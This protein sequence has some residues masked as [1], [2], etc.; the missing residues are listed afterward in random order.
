MELGEI[1]PSCFDCYVT[2]YI[3]TE[4]FFITH[5]SLWPPVKSS[6]T[7]SHR[8]LQEGKSGTITSVAPVTTE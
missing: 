5:T 4:N 2:R 6:Q 7:G 8:K 3:S 1:T